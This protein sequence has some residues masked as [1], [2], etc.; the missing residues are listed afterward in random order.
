M[1]PFHWKTRKMRRMMSSAA[2]E[3]RRREWW[4]ILDHWRC[5]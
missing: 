2:R 5:R 4:Q 3:V 1:C